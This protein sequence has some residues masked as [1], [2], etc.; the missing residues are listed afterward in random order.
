MQIKLNKKNLITVIF[1]V[2]AVILIWQFGYLDI[3]G[4]T[5]IVAGD[6]GDLSITKS[7]TSLSF[8]AERPNPVGILISEQKKHYLAH[9]KKQN[10]KLVVSKNQDKLSEQ[11]ISFD[12][13]ALNGYGTIKFEPARRSLGDKIAVEFRAGASEGVSGVFLSNKPEGGYLAP[14]IIYR[15]YFKEVLQEIKEKERRSPKFYYSYLTIIWVVIS[16]LVFL[17]I[18]DFKPSGRAQK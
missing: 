12:Q 2:V 4:N 18:F 11:T 15:E 6:S 7:K 5:A 16:L 10:I 3:T 8:V 13:I 1:A 17:M 9:E 14:R